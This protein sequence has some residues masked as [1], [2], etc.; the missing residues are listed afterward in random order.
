MNHLLD[1]HLPPQSIR[2]ALLKCL[3]GNSH[4]GAMALQFTNGHFG[5]GDYA[6]DREIRRRLSKLKKSS[7]IQEVTHLMTLTNLLMEVRQTASALLQKQK[8]TWEHSEGAVGES[9][10]ETYFAPDDG[11]IHWPMSENGVLA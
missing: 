11:L 4:I 2:R 8:A 1:F 10:G 5:S 7:C 6:S 9:R 3:K